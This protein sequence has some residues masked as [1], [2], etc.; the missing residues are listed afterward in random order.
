MRPFVDA[1]AVQNL[2]DGFRCLLK[3][4]RTNPRDSVTVQNKEAVMHLG[5]V[6]E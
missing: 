1:K 2:T 4:K 6:F 3:A 5:T